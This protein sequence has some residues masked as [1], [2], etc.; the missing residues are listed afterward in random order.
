M[1]KQNKKLNVI[2]A[3]VGFFLLFLVVLTTFLRPVFQKNSV[4]E[5]TSQNNENTPEKT[6]P[7][8]TSKELFQ[9]ISAREPINIFD[10]RSQEEFQKEH[11]KN[12]TNTTAEN[13]INLLEKNKFY[14][15]ID[16]GNSG[17]ARN[18]VANLTNGTSG[19]IFYLDGG[20]QDWK[21]S[22]FPTIS[23]GNP[24]SITDQSKISPI[25]PE[26]LKTAMQ[27]EENSLMIIDVRNADIFSFEHLKNSINIPL[28]NIEKEAEKISSGKKIVV[29]DDNAK[30]SF[31]A[32]VR[33]F[34]LN[35]FNVY[36]LSGG[37][38]A[39]KQKGYEVVK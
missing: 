19:N 10:I 38:D 33:L 35:V 26:D 24:S 9:K 20:F 31:Q 21:K 29:Y 32:A 7:K 2:V 28:P 16:D 22:N 4:S 11:L 1:D 3:T 6:A 30:L 18:L 15:V 27:N 36:V 23:T 17:L 12:S 39:W 14:I 13:I 8:I 37:L 5:N 25:S 34:D